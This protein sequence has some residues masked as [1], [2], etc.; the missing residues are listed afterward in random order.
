MGK[1]TQTRSNP[2]TNMVAEINAFLGGI[3][4]SV[5]YDSRTRMYELC[6]TEL[7]IK[8]KKFIYLS[9][10]GF[11]TFAEM[12]HYLNGILMGCRISKQLYNF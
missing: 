6:A 1:F 7:G 5:T 4:L 9:T 11:I 2:L 10:E 8:T 12:F 3:Y